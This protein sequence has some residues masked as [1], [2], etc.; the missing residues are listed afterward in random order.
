MRCSHRRRTPT[1]FPSRTH[2]HGAEDGLHVPRCGRRADGAFQNDGQA[3]ELSLPRSPREGVR[4]WTDDRGGYE[5]STRDFL[6]GCRD[7]V[8]RSG[9]LTIDRERAWRTRPGLPDELAETFT[10][11][12]ERG[13]PSP[14]GAVPMSARR[15]GAQCAACGLSL[16][17][18]LERVVLV[19][20]SPTSRPLPKA[21]AR[22]AP[23]ILDSRRCR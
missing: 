5:E 1:H 7:P 19:H 11:T 15:R 16:T 21:R 13:V 18:R 17:R 8:G 3:H 4:T 2:D 6:G 23:E 10:C 9:L 14:S 12:S 22:D 20:A